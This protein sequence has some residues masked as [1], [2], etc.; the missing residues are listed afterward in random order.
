MSEPKLETL[1]ASAMMGMLGAEAQTDR[2]VAAIS[3]GLKRQ[4]KTNKTTA[5]K[6]TNKNKRKK[7]KRVKGAR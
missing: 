6:Q 3:G 4:K 5:N 7:I 2:A 1:P